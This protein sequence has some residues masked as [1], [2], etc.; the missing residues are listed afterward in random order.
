MQK[1]NTFVT[2]EQI[3]DWISN[4]TIMQTNEWTYLIYDFWL[5][6]SWPMR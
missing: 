6:R 4:T 1:M 5:L 2:T 3:P